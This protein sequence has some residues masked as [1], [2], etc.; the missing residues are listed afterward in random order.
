MKKKV[1][2]LF[3]FVLLITGV[4][5][6]CSG[7]EQSSSGASDDGQV[8]VQVWFG[9][10]D[11][12]PADN[13]DSFHEEH[14]DIKV[15]TDVIPLEQSV[16]DYTRNFNAGNAPDIFQTYHE[17]VPVLVNQ[18]SVMDMTEQFK[19]WENDDPE[20][21]NNLISQAFETTS[22]DGKSYGLGIHM[23][24]RWHV[25]RKDLFEEAGLDAPET[26]DDVIE[27]AR[28]LKEGGY[29]EAGQYPYAIVAGAENAPNWFQSQFQA[30]GGEYKDGI[31]QLDSE[32]GTYLIDFYQTLAKE[33]LIHPESIA[34]QSGEMR[35]AFIGGNAAMATIG[36]NIFPIINE[37]LSEYGDKWE[38]TVQPHRPGAEESWRPNASTWPMMVSENTEHPEE[39]TEVLKY[40]SST[41]IVKEVAHRYQATTN[42]EVMKDESYYEEKPWHENLAEDYEKAENIPSSLA[43]PQVMD[44]LLELMQECLQNP[45]KDP[46]ELAKT[47]QAEF[48]EIS[49]N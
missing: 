7:D 28:T 43:H 32:A 40:L 12:I 11:F 29:L 39:V 16:S 18:G 14:P 17:N 27:A 41:D 36:D 15:E 19:Q 26:W 9:R 23:G 25:H 21:F 35:G 49:S 30:M 10:E 38:A 45:D 8:T 24:P 5:V 3:G 31:P 47:Y 20:S 48:E 34:W 2:V 37:D 6:G 46:S 1:F 22:Y 42:S 33:E 4:V 13:F 44:T